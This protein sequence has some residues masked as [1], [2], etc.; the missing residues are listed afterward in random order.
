MAGNKKSIASCLIDHH[1]E[2]VHP[3]DYSFKAISEF[4]GEINFDLKQINFII[5]LYRSVER[6]TKKKR[7]QI[8]CVQ[9]IVLYTYG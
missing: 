9:V 8:S 4:S 5:T 2:I 3:L 7:W 1:K 6:E